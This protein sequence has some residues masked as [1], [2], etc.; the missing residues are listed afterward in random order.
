VS[1]GDVKPHGYAASG[2]SPGRVRLADVDDVQSLRA[3]E[4]GY[5][6]GTPAL[7]PEAGPQPA[8][9]AR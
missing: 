8:P 7:R 1:E 5:L 6:H 2:V 9:E 4:A 3:A